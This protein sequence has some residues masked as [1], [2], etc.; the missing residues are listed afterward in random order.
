M[1]K[2]VF[3][4]FWGG[5]R[6]KASADAVSLGLCDFCARSDGT[7]ARQELLREADHRAFLEDLHDG[8]YR[9]LLAEHASFTSYAV[10]KWHL[11]YAHWNNTPTGRGFKGHVG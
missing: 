10:G 11:G 8:A 6:R 2:S 7:L 4:A 3:P 9:E 5:D 1:P